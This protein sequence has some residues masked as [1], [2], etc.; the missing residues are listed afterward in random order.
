LVA[1]FSPFVS[2]RLDLLSSK[3]LPHLL[4]DDHF[5]LHPPCFSLCRVV[6]R[7]RSRPT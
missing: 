5:T 4:F 3:L 2:S 1:R 7:K 6:I